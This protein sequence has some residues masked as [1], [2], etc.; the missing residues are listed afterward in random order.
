MADLRTLFESLGFRDVQT[1]IQSGNAVFASCASAKALDDTKEEALGLD[2]KISE[3]IKEKYSFEVP[4]LVKTVDQ[5]QQIITHSPFSEEKL[6]KSYFILLKTE[7]ERDH[8]LEIQKM[9]TPDEEFLITSNVVYIFYALGAGKAKLSN[10]WFE[11]K[12]NVKATAR[13]Y[14]TMAKLLELAAH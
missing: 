6:L 10:N 12:L 13:N 1:Y 9:S 14:R 2:V 11:K 7:P 4:V 5:I 3:A 8:V